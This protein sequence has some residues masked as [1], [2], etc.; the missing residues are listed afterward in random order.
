LVV[1]Q[2]NGLFKI[3]DA[4]LRELV[5]RVRFLEREIGGEITYNAVPRKQNQRADFLVNQALDSPHV[6]ERV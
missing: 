6:G 4:R 2:L 1:N 3:K 5:L